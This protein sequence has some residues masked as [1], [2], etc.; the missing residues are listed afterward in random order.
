[1]RILTIDQG[2][3]GTTVFVLDERCS[4]LGK[5]YRE[6]PQ[7]FPQP[8][9]VEH[10]PEAIWRT[11]LESTADALEQSATKA[12]DIGAIGVTN[13][14]ETIVAWDVETGQPIGPTIVWQD[15][16]TGPMCDQ[17]RL[18]GEDARIRELTG[19]PVD[20]YFSGTKI[21]WLL[22]NDRDVATAAERGTLRLGT[23]DSWIAWRASGGTAHITDASN[24]ARTMLYDIHA[25][26][27]SPEL[28]RL[29]GVEE[30]WL[31]TVVDCSGTLAHSNPDAL[32]GIDAPLTGM[33]GDQQAAL[34]GQACFTPGQAKAT[35]GT[36]A[37]VVVNSGSL[38]PTTEQLIST[39]GWTIGGTPTFALEGSVFT[40]GASVQWL[41]DGLQIIES[42]PETEALAASVPDSGGVV[43]IPAF[44]GL[45]APH[46]DANARAGLLGITRG[47]TRAHVAR[48]T[49]EAVAC[50]VKELVDAMQSEGTSV[51]ELR[52]DGGMAANNLLMQMQADILGIPVTRPTHVETTA[53][54]AA[55][56][57][58][59]GAGVVDMDELSKLWEADRRFEPDASR[60]N[61]AETQ[62]E[63]FA[64]ATAA[65]RALPAWQESSEADAARARSTQ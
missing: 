39:I 38:A 20:P 28:L 35:Y 22:K 32:L 21:A 14:R 18:D 25:G 26:T 15:R 36:G 56:L 41:R 64:A 16:R 33:A 63:R 23:I 47:T 24:A 4:V 49:L 30:A 65:I 62:M 5:G 53:L 29:F 42:A 58:A 59:L 3:T 17:L 60:A 2:T 52:V 9:W 12:G 46:W 19:L 55:Y 11:V 57:A 6:H 45:G 7:H 50:R 27:W 37:F 48:A 54:G 8:G 34:F 40:A 61:W 1:M 51:T 43:L 13:Q 44:A 31:P 10:D